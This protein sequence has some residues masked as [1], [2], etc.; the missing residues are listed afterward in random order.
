MY[1]IYVA[2]KI[3]P[4]QKQRSGLIAAY[5]HCDTNAVRYQLSKFSN[6]NLFIL[7]ADCM[8]RLLR[9]DGFYPGSTH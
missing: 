5:D 4:E 3:K 6:E 7:F 1:A 9:S 2:A 8:K